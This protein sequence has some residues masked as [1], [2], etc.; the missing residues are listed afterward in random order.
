MTYPDPDK[1]IDDYDTS[2]GGSGSLASFMSGARLQAKGNWVTAYT[3]QA[4]CAWFQ[5]NFGMVV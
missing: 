1:T 2:I 4:V 3:A 5:N